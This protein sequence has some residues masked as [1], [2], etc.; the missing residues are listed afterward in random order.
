M[1]RTIVSREP[2]G[3][4]TAVDAGTESPRSALPAGEEAKFLGGS[5]NFNINWLN[6]SY[7]GADI[8]VIAHL[9]TPT[10][11]SEIEEIDQAIEESVDIQ[12]GASNYLNNVTSPMMFFA[13]YPA[14]GNNYQDRAF[15]AVIGTGLKPNAIEYLY[16]ELFPAF[17]QLY[18]GTPDNVGQI[19][20][21]SIFEEQSQVQASLQERKEALK[22]MNDASSNTITLENLQTI[23]VQSF[24]EKNAVR[25]LGKS[26]VSGYTRG[27]RSLGGSMIFTMIREHPLARL[28]RAMG[29]AGLAGET[30]YDMATSTLIPDQLPPLD[31]T[32]VFANEYGSISQMGIYGVEFATDGLTL[33]SE[34]MLTEVVL[35]FVARDID[36]P[37]SV[38]MMKLSQGER[39]I[40]AQD[41]HKLSAS[42]LYTNSQDS[43]NRFLEKVGLRNSFKG[44]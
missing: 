34:D 29:N 25:S 23:S 24:R 27:P 11:N 26:Y 22:K 36:I 43:Y 2:Q 15:R 13:R 28:V 42:E 31:L 30:V 18:R 9:Y 41:G 33:S 14:T 20:A 12:E 37:S 3:G 10:T 40:Y 39:G 17:L 5:G 32:V 7:A 44:R 16:A 38:G 35:Q 8:K 21:D 6:G 19:V 1:T 4:T